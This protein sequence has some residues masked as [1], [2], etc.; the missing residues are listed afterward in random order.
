MLEK[1]HCRTDPLRWETRTSPRPVAM[2]WEGKGLL[3][4]AD[5]GKG[6]PAAPV[7]PQLRTNP[8]V[9]FTVRVWEPGKEEL[10]RY[11]LGDTQH[12]C[13]RLEG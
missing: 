1:L 8:G 2:P 7:F 10:P 5:N 11:H 3:H 4:S 13:L 9:Q 12:R 6:L